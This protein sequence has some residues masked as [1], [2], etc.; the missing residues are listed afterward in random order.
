[1]RKGLF[2][3]GIQLSHGPNTGAPSLTAAG[4]SLLGHPNDVTS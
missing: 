4:Q 3:R 2:D 1:V